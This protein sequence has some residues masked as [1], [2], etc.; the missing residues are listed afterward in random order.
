M[1]LLLLL[2]CVL[3]QRKQYFIT[4]T[5]FHSIF[6]FSHSLK[7]GMARLEGQQGGGDR[8]RCN[9]MYFAFALRAFC[10]SFYGNSLRCPP[11]PPSH[12]HCAQCALWRPQVLS[13]A[14]RSSQFSELAQFRL[15]RISY[16]SIL[17]R[18][19]MF[20]FY[21][22]FLCSALGQCF[23]LQLFIVVLRLVF[24]RVCCAL[25]FYGSVCMLCRTFPRGVVVP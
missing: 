13:S 17:N 8:W 21:C 14:V 9:G 7:Q 6:I 20:E 2:S 4:F 23:F 22:I 1:F 12:G 16:V 5:Y 18:L 15:L 10:F 25:L 3:C 19:F 11:L 24:F